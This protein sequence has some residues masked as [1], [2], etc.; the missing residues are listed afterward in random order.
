MAYY[1]IASLEVGRLLT[2]TEYRLHN[3]KVAND[4]RLTRQRQQ[5]ERNRLGDIIAEKSCVISNQ[6][7][8]QTKSAISQII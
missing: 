5:M 6:M 3:Q 7:L 4:N 8:C 1:P 2:K